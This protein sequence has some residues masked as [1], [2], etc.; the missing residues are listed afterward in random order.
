MPD[1]TSITISLLHATRGRPELAA[2]CRSQ[3][4]A[5]AKHPQRVEHLFAIDHDDAAS[6]A[7]LAELP[8]VVVTEGEGCVAA[9]NLAAEQCRGNIL[10]QLSDD[11]EAPEGWDDALSQ[12]LPDPK[13]EAVLAVGDACRTDEILTM[14]IL[15]RARY[16]AQGH[17]F[18]PG[19]FS[20]MSDYE[21]THRAYRDGIVVEARDLVFR[22]LHA[23]TGAR[24]WDETYARQNAGEHYRAGFDHFI[25][26]NPDA[27][28]NWPL[29][30]RLRFRLRR[31]LESLG[32]LTRR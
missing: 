21:F 19:Y 18:H 2:A 27:L 8:Q 30:K 15:T 31:L 1:P 14:A 25:A 4:L 26:R 24:D 5:A 28:R 12:R 20:M 10:V 29:N 22:H 6:L 3:F 32:L 9:W 17:L 7:A 16:L 13:K 11:W 23:N